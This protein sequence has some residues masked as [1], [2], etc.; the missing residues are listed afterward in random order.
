MPSPT[1]PQS[2]M[3]WHLRLEALLLQQVRT[4]GLPA[5]KLYLTVM[6]A[7]GTASRKKKN[8]SRFG[9]SLY[10][11]YFVPSPWL[12][13]EETKHD[14]YGS[15]VQVGGENKDKQAVPRAREMEI[16]LRNKRKTSREVKEGYCGV[17]ACYNSQGGPL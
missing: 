13:A 1:S 3:L 17:D 2:L 9:P 7:G 15:Y 6:A 10:Y 16:R 12:N 11:T 4:K 14:R 5:A 8:S